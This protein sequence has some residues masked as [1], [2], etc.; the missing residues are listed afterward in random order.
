MGMACWGLVLVALLPACSSVAVCASARATVASVCRVSVQSLSTVHSCL[1]LCALHASSRVAQATCDARIRT[2]KLSL[3]DLAGSERVDK[4]GTKGERLD[5]GKSINK[6]LL[7]LVT[8]I[9]G[10]TSRK[11]TSSSPVHVPYRDSV[12]TWLL[13]DS[14]G[15]NAHS[16]MIATVSPEQ[17]NVDETR[18]TLRY[19][20]RAKKVVTH[21]RV[22]EDPRSFL[23]DSLQEEVK[24][25]KLKLV[26]VATN[27]ASSSAELGSIV[28]QIRGPEQQMTS[29][30][31]T[32]EQRLREAKEYAY[33]VLALPRLS[34]ITPSLLRLAL[35]STALHPP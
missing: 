9:N 17:G 12:L 25:L 10:L 14:L 32:T 5:E 30:E 16:T 26:E 11:A 29:L 1:P 35:P 31:K 34:F 23:V 21:A 19:A 20:E 3:V 22:N 8:V 24:R 7:A 18:A 6:S 28:E 13:R 27:D 15:G 33:A 2:S 4:A